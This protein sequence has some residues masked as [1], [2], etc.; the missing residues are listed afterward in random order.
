MRTWRNVASRPSFVAVEN[1]LL[2]TTTKTPLEAEVVKDVVEC[3]E[4][5]NV[6]LHSTRRSGATNVLKKHNF[7]VAEAHGTEFVE[8]VGN[9]LLK[10]VGEA[11]DAPLRANNDAQNARGPSRDTFSEY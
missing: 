11:R 4:K 3:Q 5:N 2:T 1:R 6:R 7:Y 10:N 8:S 9:A